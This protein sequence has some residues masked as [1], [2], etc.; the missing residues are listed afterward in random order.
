MSSLETRQAELQNRISQIDAE[1]SKL[2][3]DFTALAASFNGTDGRA[4]LK[5]AERIEQRLIQLRR[6]KALTI[7][8][9][10]HVTR[11]QLAEKEAQAE[12]DRRAVQATAKQLAE[13]IC[14][15]NAAIDQ[16][17]KQLFEAFQRRA[18][19]F[20]DLGNTGL[21]D[22]AVINKL[23]GKGA[24]TRAACAAHLHAHL[25]LEKVAQGSFVT[26]SS[27]N[28]ILLGIGRDHTP[29]PPDLGDRRGANGD[30][31]NGGT[32]RHRRN[33]GDA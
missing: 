6:E 12:A 9:Q 18:S 8:S 23:A 17:L 4:S 5:A 1:I 13:G 22:S 19:L 31:S 7:A 20:H 16:M 27:T 29:D 32:P 14:S 2:D 21:I 11:E 26:L 3:E 15:A 24:A 30:G 25:A 28:P 10:A 33:G